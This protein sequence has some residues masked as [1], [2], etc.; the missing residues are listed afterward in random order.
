MLDMLF[1]CVSGV[2]VWAVHAEAKPLQ[3]TGLSGVV[4][5]CLRTVVNMGIWVHDHRDVERSGYVSMLHK[6]YTP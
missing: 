4:K 3:T 2:G 1:D 5:S 6:L